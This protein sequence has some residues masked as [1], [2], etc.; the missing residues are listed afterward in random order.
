MTDNLLRCSTCVFSSSAWWNDNTPMSRIP[1]LA[2]AAHSWLLKELR[3]TA[4]ES[5]RWISCLTTTK[6]RS[7]VCLNTCCIKYSHQTFW[8]SLRLF[9]MTQLHLN[10]N[11]SFEFLSTLRIT[12][13][14]AFS[15]RVI[16]K[17]ARR[18]W[19]FPVTFYTLL[20]DY[21]IQELFTKTI[22]VQ[23]SHC[24]KAVQGFKYW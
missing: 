12:I 22:D 6:T 24:L 16:T 17:A 21:Q 14:S 5:Y 8:S 10:F 2:L 15:E 4:K 11:L 3:M 13:V 20:K 19:R 18:C 9:A 23:L 1:S 7:H